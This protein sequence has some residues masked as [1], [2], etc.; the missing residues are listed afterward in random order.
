MD[1]LNNFPGASKK[2]TPTTGTQQGN[3]QDFD[4]DNPFYLWWL[5]LNFKETHSAYYYYGI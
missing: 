2:P 5:T 4:R 3:Q 1:R